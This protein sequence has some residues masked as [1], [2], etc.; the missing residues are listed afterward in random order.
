MS[1]ERCKNKFIVVPTLPQN[2]VQNETCGWLTIG[3]TGVILPNSAQAEQ[4]G[5]DMRWNVCA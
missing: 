5:S 2:L 4:S 3:D 1:A